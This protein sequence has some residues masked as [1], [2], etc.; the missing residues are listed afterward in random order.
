MVNKQLLF[1]ILLV[2]VLGV[3]GAVLQFSKQA[4]TQKVSSVI[5]TDKAVAESKRLF[6][7][8]LEAGTDISVGPCLSNDLMPDWVTDVVHSPREPVDDLP[9]N[10]CQA[11]F[12]G[13]AKHF[14]EL[15]TS[16]NL[17]RVR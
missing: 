12:E 13:R 9:Q 2:F 17:I 5:T 15:D 7:R 14:V 4:P 1:I 6:R 16:G 10:Q 11:Y 8:A 3:G